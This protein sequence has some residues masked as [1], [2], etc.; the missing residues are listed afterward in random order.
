MEY[1]SKYYEKADNMEITMN[2]SNLMK[3]DETTN[4]SFK[5]LNAIA[6][7]VLGG[8]RKLKNNGMLKITLKI[9]LNNNMKIKQRVD[10]AKLAARLNDIHVSI[11]ITSNDPNK[12]PTNLNSYVLVPRIKRIYRPDYYVENY[13]AGNWDA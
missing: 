3:G 7:N 6:N 11:Q 4:K 1:F 9:M 8:D 5:K 13:K 12:K 10:A 2:T